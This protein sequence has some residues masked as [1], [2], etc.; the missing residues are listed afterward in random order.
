MAQWKILG[1]LMTQWGNWK[2]LMKQWGNYYVG[3]AKWPD[4][5]TGNWA[6]AWWP[7]GRSWALGDVMGKLEILAMVKS[8]PLYDLMGKLGPRPRIIFKRFNINT[9]PSLY[10]TFS[11][12][13][14]PNF[15]WEILDDSASWKKS[16][17]APIPH[18]SS[19]LS[20]IVW[21]LPMFDFCIFCHLL[22]LMG[23]GYIELLYR[24]GA[25]SEYLKSFVPFF[26]SSSSFLPFLFFSFL[27]FICFSCLFLRGPL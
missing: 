22:R 13:W 15:N 20:K 1:P 27:F 23:R 5:E 25:P 14:A 3:E 19:H 7:N 12:I 11:N 16:H 8:G 6:Q 17:K 4:G 9:A 10:C 21:W 24:V 18:F 26:F 2:P